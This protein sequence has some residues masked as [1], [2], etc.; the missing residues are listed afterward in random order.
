MKLLIK[1]KSKNEKIIFYDPIEKF[2]NKNQCN[3]K[4]KNDIFVMIDKVHPSVEFSK[5]I[6]NNFNFLL[7][8][9]IN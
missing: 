1:Q 3:F 4:L 6:S 5:S 7:R 2:C 8:S 9:L